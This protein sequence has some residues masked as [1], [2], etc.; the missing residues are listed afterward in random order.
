MPFALFNCSHLSYIVVALSSSVTDLSNKA[1]ILYDFQE[2]TIQFHDFPG[3]EN[4]MLKFHDFPFFMTCT[5]PDQHVGR[6]VMCKGSI[7]LLIGAQR[8]S[9]RKSKL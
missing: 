4:E 7:L 1:L 8:L 2:P 9:L 5:N 6:D 3:L